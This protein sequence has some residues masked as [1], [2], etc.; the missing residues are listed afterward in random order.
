MPSILIIAA[1]RGLGLGLVGEFFERGW[2]V[3]G[4]GR[5]GADTGDLEAVGT[6]DPGRLLLAAIDVTDADAIEPLLA[7]LGTRR[8]DVIF[9]NAGIWG[10]PHQSVAQASN[11]ELA[12]IMLVNC[13][14]PIRLAHRLL[15]HL[16]P[17]GAYAFMSSHRGS[18]ALN[19][20]GGLELYRASK[21]AL[22]ML[23]RGLWAANRERE[24]TVLS[25]HPGGCEPRWARSAARWIPRWSWSRASAASPMSSNATGPRARTCTAIGR[26]GRSAGDPSS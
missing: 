24:L 18:A 25:I 16:K 7:A 9:F 4:T 10:A 21:V 12:E 11:A 15:G 20:E 5:P 6:A 19:L 13:S 22:N 1:D 8:Y 26:T 3:T 14:G 2:A 23:A 17:G